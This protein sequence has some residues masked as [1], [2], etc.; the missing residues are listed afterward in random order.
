MLRLDLNDSLGPT[1]LAA[2]VALLIAVRT[3]MLLAQRV[4]RPTHVIR[5]IYG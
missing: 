2:G 5:R 1:A 3:S 4:L